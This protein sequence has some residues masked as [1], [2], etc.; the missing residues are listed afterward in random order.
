MSRT[1]SVV[2]VELCLLA[3]ALALGQGCATSSDCASTA[4][5]LEKVSGGIPDESS[6]PISRQRAMELA[7]EGGLEEGLTPW[8]VELRG[9]GRGGFVWVVQNTMFDGPEG[10]GGRVLRV[11]TRSG[12]ILEAV[13]W[14]ATRGR[15]N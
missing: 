3:A 13:S 4:T 11:C 8:T 15:R 12:E 6:F 1:L 7:R 2:F 5:N 9:D 10:R 14:E